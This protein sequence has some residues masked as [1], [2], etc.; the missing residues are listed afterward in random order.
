M[1]TNTNLVTSVVEKDVH[2]P[3]C[4]NEKGL[5]I[6]QPTIKKSTLQLPE[7]GIKFVL[8]FLYLAFVQILT[9]GY[10]LFEIK[11][12]YRHTT[13]AFCPNCG[14]T[15]SMA[16][17]ETIKREVQEP[18]L[19]RHREG[20]IASGLCLGIAELTGLSV[21]RVRLITTLYCLAVFPAFF[22]FL[23]SVLTPF[24]DET[25]EDLSKGKLYR[26]RKGKD[27]MGLCQGISAYTGIAVWFVRLLMICTGPVYF[28]IALFFPVKEDLE[29]GIERKNLHKCQEGKWI[30]GVCTGY[31]QYLGW[32]LWIV[33]VLA[34]LFPYVY[35][36]SG[37]LMSTEDEVPYAE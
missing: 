11:N 14:N 37:A 25:P 3:Y 33:R 15:F 12:E 7:V 10:K 19:R 16:P 22:Y 26:L 35:L 9:Q 4:N 13:Y 21:A 2:C 30:L 24:E 31:A 23:A 29:Q 17:P 5:M 8:L 27:L 28:L 18:K 6:S 36:I 20:K 1:A 32:K 34:V